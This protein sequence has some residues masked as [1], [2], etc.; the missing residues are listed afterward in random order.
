MGNMAAQSSYRRVK[1]EKCRRSMN[2]W[3]IKQRG[4]DK[5]LNFQLNN[6]INSLV[7]DS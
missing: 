3:T 1:I 2:G 5:E 6:F 4:E 7:T